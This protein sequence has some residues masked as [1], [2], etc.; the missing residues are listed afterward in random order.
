VNDK[1]YGEHG[2]PCARLRYTYDWGDLDGE[3][4]LSEFII[5]AGASVEIH[6]VTETQDYC[7]P[8]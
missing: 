3:V 8:N 7:N 2:Y 5:R 1:L 6:S 4:G